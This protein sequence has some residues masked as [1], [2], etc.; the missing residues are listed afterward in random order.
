MTVR[1]CVLP[2]VIQ[3]L[4]VHS[5]TAPS[6][7]DDLLLELEDLEDARDLVARIS[8]DECGWLAHALREK[9]ARDEE[10][11]YQDIERDLEVSLP[12]T[13]ILLHL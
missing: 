1:H 6:H 12:N 7:I 5:E 3:T 2:V 8:P 10:R 11:M 9:I 13:Y 4:T